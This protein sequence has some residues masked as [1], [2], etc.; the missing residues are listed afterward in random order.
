MAERGGYVGGPGGA[1]RVS[2]V[3]FCSTAAA[4]LEAES[5]CAL[6]LTDI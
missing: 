3:N 4:M 6:V 1:M 5:L 2:V